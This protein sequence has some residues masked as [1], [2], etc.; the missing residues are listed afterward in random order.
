MICWRCSGW[1]YLSAGPAGPF[2]LHPPLRSVDVRP[3]AA[4]DL[5]K[6]NPL[7][8]RVGVSAPNPNTVSSLMTCK[9]STGHARGLLFKGC[10]CSCVFQLHLKKKMFLCVCVRAARWDLVQNTAKDK[11][12]AA[13]LLPCKRHLHGCVYC[14]RNCTLQHTQLER[15]LVKFRGTTM[16]EHGAVCV[17]RAGNEQPWCSVP[18]QARCQS[19]W[20]RSRPIWQLHT[21]VCPRRWVPVSI[22]R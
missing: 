12:Q 9:E 8:P 20:A 19:C 3:P 13:M 5:Q 11:C 6:T 1:R 2:G 15:L 4:T 16:F 14:K 7:W 22:W 17:R 10:S 21:T 18:C